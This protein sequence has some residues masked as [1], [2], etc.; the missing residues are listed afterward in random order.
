M[1]EWARKVSLY[2]WYHG[3]A[4]LIFKLYVAFS[5]LY[6]SLLISFVLFWRISSSFA[7]SFSTKNSWIFNGWRMGIWGQQLHCPLG[8][9]GQWAVCSGQFNL[10][11]TALPRDFSGQVVWAVQFWAVLGSSWAVFWVVFLDIFRFDFG[12]F[13]ICSNFLP[14]NHRNYIFLLILTNKKVKI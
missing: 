1:S 7:F 14:E 6:C 12:K 4:A 10:H 8:S 11:C 5:N 9:F 3:Q 13:L 2:F